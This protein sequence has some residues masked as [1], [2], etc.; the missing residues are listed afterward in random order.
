MRMKTMVWTG[1]FVLCLLSGCKDKQE[2]V[3]LKEVQQEEEGSIQDESRQSESGQDEVLQDGGSG[4]SDQITSGVADG[5]IFVDVC[6]QV[7][8]PGVYGLPVGSRVYEAVE[9][10]GGMTEDAAASAV[11]QAQK[12]E[13]AQQVYVP[14]EREISQGTS[15]VQSQEPGASQ[16][17]DSGKVNINTAVKEELMTLTGIGEVKADS[18]IRYRQ[19]QGS[20][21]KPEDLKNVE[22]I[23]DG[24]YEKVKDQITV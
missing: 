14:S 16:N 15:F 2:D 3:V 7:R 8:R 23:K 17:A 1:L 22:G 12:L 13:D 11:N 20:F 10:A 19:E 5:M 18:I 9:M 6:G 4:S 24:L 21:K